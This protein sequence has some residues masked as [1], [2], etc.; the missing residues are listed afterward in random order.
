MTDIQLRLCTEM[1]LDTVYTIEQRSFSTPWSRESFQSALTA[2][3]TEIW[4]LTDENE[5]IRGFG[6]VMT[7]AGDGEVLNIAVDPDYRGMGYGDKLLL[8]LLDSAV[9]NEAEQVFL[10]VRE[11]N[12]AARNLYEKHGF[13]PIGIR[14]RY[15]S[16]PTE[17]AVCM[18]CDLQNRGNN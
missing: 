7:I 18:C 13:Q 2:V 16:N 11:S 4:L 17:D 12:T 3:G 15:Y 8:A 6:C 10:E 9:R 14:K 5:K 1:D